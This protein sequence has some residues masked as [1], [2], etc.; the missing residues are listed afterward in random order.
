MTWL[1]DLRMA[2]LLDDAGLAIVGWTGL[3][4]ALLL[5]SGLWAW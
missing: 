2:L 4:M 5:L 3:A 1:Y